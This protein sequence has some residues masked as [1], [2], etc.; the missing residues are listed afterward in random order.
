M[1]HIARSAKLVLPDQLP[2]T[3]INCDTNKQANYLAVC[4]DV[5]RKESRYAVGNYA[6]VIQELLAANDVN[7][8]ILFTESQNSPYRELEKYGAH[9]CP[10]CNVEKF[11]KEVSKCRWVISSEGGSA[12]IAGALGLGVIVLSGMG[13]QTYWR[14]YARFVR[15]LDQKNAVNDIEVDTIISE[16]RN[17]K[18]QM[19]LSE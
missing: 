7:K 11:I 1:A 19:S 14:P 9:W 10:T 18:S 4:P 8:V 15:V 17:L 2:Y 6:K 13:H 5:N 16:F 3:Y 12:H